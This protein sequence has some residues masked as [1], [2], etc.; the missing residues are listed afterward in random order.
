[1]IKH[2]HLK[3]ACHLRDWHHYVYQTG[4]SPY[5]GFLALFFILNCPL[6][7]AE[8]HDCAHELLEQY[9]I[10][11]NETDPILRDRLK[12]AYKSGAVS[13]RSPISTAI[14]IQ[15]Y[16]IANT[17]GFGAISNCELQQALEQVNTHF[18]E[19]GFSFF[20]TGVHTINS[21]KYFSIKDFEEG[22]SLYLTLNN[23]NA[24]NIY[25]VD[26]SAGYCGWANFPWSNKKYIL[27]SNYCTTN[28]STFAHE[29][30]HYLGLL[31]THSTSS[32]A[33]LVDGSNCDSAG[34]LLCDTPADP[35]LSG[36]VD[37]D[38]SYTGSTTDANNE[39]YTPDT[40]NLMSYSL[41]DCRTKFS[42]DQINRMDFYYTNIRAD[43]LT[44]TN[45]VNLNCPCTNDSDQD[46][47]CDENDACADFPDVDSD[48]NGVADACDAC[49]IMNFEDY[50][51]HEFSGQ[52]DGDEDVLDNGATVRI[53]Q[54][55]WKA[56]ALNYTITPNTVLEFDFASFIEGE[57]HSIAFDDE[58]VFPPASQLK[59]Y[60]TEST[61]DMM[62]GAYTYTSNGAYQ[63]FSIPIGTVMT[64]FYDYLIFVTDQ[65]VGPQDAN[66]YFR[67]VKIYEDTNNDLSC[68]LTVL[69]PVELSWFEGRQDNCA[70]LLEWK[71][72]IEENFDYYELEWSEDGRMFSTKAILKGN[73][74]ADPSY[75][76][77]TDQILEAT[78]Y[79]R[80]K[81]VDLDGSFE[82][83]D[84]IYIENNCQNNPNTFI[85]P[86]PIHQY[87][88]Q[89]HIELLSQKKEEQFLLINQF[90]VP[91]QRFQ[92]STAGHKTVH[93]LNLA[94][95]PAGVYFIQQVGT[96]QT[97][98]L[99]LLD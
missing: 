14:P 90:G 80:L 35:N 34:D 94:D 85:Y 89:L 27:I 70:N 37:A 12:R 49:T 50:T 61:T 55:G 11:Q 28:S 87:A 30:G 41:K 18:A 38:C 10:Q 71:S 36:G 56:I 83:S 42:A 66:S 76:S 21:D 19:T 8:P 25:F 74:G 32:G 58:L 95:F 68:D 78:N 52:D 15:A 62:D 9:R 5:K 77:Y 84:L 60:G 82:Y 91:L 86:N 59:L 99:I 31:H 48:N 79:Y 3:M 17:H 24:I 88:E 43:Q 69:L 40:D 4:Y 7:H 98:K 39:T 72:E 64:G 22:D 29:L 93:T 20:Y 75:Y 73:G 54:N 1:M 16:V 81:M 96:L 53:E 23:P 6:I 63:H 67:N 33:E 2:L 44:S 92:V 26:Y 47:I 57:H 65:D 13:F 97:Q 45:L 51:F 46:G